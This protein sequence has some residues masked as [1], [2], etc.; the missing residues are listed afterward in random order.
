MQQ[1]IHYFLHFGFPLIV[2]LAIDRSKWLRMYGILLL[3]MLVDLDHLFANP[4]FD[5]CRCSIGFHPLHSYPAIAAYILLLLPRKTRIVAIGLLL[6]MA[7][8]GIDC[9]FIMKHC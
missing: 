6:H 9:L 8:D 3:T 1:A 7:T 5:P 2:A 4:I